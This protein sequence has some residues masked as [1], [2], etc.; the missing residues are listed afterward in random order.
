MRLACLFVAIFVVA[1]SSIDNDS[2][3]A[4]SILCD[5]GSVVPV[6]PMAGILTLLPVDNTGHPDWWHR[7]RG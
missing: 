2:N 6:D 7:R 5:C 1:S 4:S 3:V